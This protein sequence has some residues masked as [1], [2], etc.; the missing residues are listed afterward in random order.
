MVR[1][2]GV[3]LVAD[4]WAKRLCNLGWD[5]TIACLRSD[6]TYAGDNLVHV[7]A[8]ATEILTLCKQ[9]DIDLVMAQTSPYFEIL[10]AIAMQ[11]PTIA[12]EHGDPTPFFFKHDRQERESI[13]HNKIQHVYPNVSR[14]L[15]SSHFLRHDIQWTTSSVVPLG[16]D[17][18]GD[19]GQKEFSSVSHLL[20]L[21]IGTLMRLGEGESLYK[22]V[23]IYADLASSLKN[24][25]NFVFHI[26][27]RGQDTDRASWESIGVKTFLNADDEER[28][29]Y[30]RD[31]D[32]LISPSLWEGF[33]L[34]VVEAAASGTVGVAFDIGAHPET[35]PFLVR[36]PIDL[37]EL[38]QAWANDRAL[39]SKA[40]HDAYLFARK[41]FNWE[42]SSQLLSEHLSEVLGLYKR[43]RRYL[44]FFLL[45]VL[46]ALAREGIRGFT[47]LA[48]TKVRQN[49][50]R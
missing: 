2:Y 35:T 42:E 10:P 20:P 6:E 3:S 40:S 39:L 5:T 4:E 24:D 33:N 29:K 44:D 30:L 1:G 12:F 23:E 28:S 36:D 8:D 13:K 31:L 26:M 27:G 49:L 15:A 19:F 47:R 37:R 11:F 41:K 22:G 38:L 46:R 18:V 34:P 9:L 43:R 45:R 25:P 50:R 48:I 7:G 21:Q 14:V 32:V 17:H 16:C